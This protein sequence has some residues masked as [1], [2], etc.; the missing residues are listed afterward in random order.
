[1][2]KVL[3][4]KMAAFLHRLKRASDERFDAMQQYQK[5][6]QRLILLDSDIEHY[7][8]RYR[9]A[10]QELEKL[11]GLNDLCEVDLPRLL[12]ELNTR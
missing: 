6:A 12:R 5:L 4:A 7:Q 3:R 2:D 1:M 11:E 9:E 10:E 8:A